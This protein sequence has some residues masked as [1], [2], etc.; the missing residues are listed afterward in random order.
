MKWRS[1]ELL[2]NSVPSR[3][4]ILRNLV[5]DECF[6]S[7][8]AVDSSHWEIAQ[9]FCI[10][11]HSS[12][13]SF[14]WSDYLCRICV[15]RK[16]HL[17]L[18]GS[19][20]FL[21]SVFFS[22]VEM[23]RTGILRPLLSLFLDCYIF[24]FL[25]GY[26]ARFI[27]EI[28]LLLSAGTHTLWSVIMQTGPEIYTGDVSWCI[29]LLTWEIFYGFRRLISSEIAL[30]QCQNRGDEIQHITDKILYIRII[31]VKQ[32]MLR[33]ATPCRTHCNI[34]EVRTHAQVR[35]VGRTSIVTAVC[36]KKYRWHVEFC[37]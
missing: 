3:L 27:S 23:S 28:T 29:D 34:G 14:P 36:L 18:L 19:A 37:C 20:R 11:P 1:Y 4:E 21:K 5:R 8:S 17:D 25:I 15:S 24:S 22:F 9:L 30:I 31:V 32:G 2:Q 13:C 26:T 6:S 16:L 12:A 33:D 10:Y 35:A 7:A